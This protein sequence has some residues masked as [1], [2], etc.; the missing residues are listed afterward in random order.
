MNVQQ[1][2]QAKQVF[3]EQNPELKPFQQQLDKLLEKSDNRYE[4]CVDLCRQWRKTHEIELKV[5]NELLD[6]HQRLLNEL[7]NILE[8]DIQ[9]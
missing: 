9:R 3:L 1:L 7:R 6:N 8:Y 4:T 2:E 5:A